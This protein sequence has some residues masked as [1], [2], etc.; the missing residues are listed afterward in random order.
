M[1]VDCSD[2]SGPK[3]PQTGR[4]PLPIEEVA[5]RTAHTTHSAHSTHNAHGAQ[6]AVQTEHYQNF[7]AKLNEWGLDSTKHVVVY[8]SNS[9]AFAG[10][11]WWLLHYYGHRN[12][13]VLDGGIGQWKFEFESGVRMPKK[14]NGYRAEMQRDMIVNAEDVES[15]RNDRNFVLVD[16]RS[17]PRYNGLEEPIDPVAGHIP[18]AVNRFHGL[19]ID[20]DGK[21]KSVVDLSNEWNPLVGNVDDQHVV[22]YCGSGVTLTQNLI[23][24]HRIGRQN[25]RIYPGSWSEWIRDS[26]RPIA[27]NKN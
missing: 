10:R 20:K 17:A 19:N 6:R 26:T 14:G 3:T 24:L 22:L 5:Q 25:V 11:L 15:I 27:T 23:A 18:G 4:H 1:R 9:G 21:F 12:V 8:D 13:S 2:L 7:I 16:S